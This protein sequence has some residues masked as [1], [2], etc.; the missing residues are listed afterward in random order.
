ML[1]AFV[2]ILI[3]DFALKAFWF[4]LATQ[5]QTRSKRLNMRWN[6]QKTNSEMNTTMIRLH[7]EL[8][9]SWFQAVSFPGGRW[10]SEGPPSSELTLRLLQCAPCFQSIAL[11]RL[12]AHSTTSV[13]GTHD[14]QSTALSTFQDPSG[15]LKLRVHQMTH[16]HT[17]THT[18]VHTHT[19]VWIQVHILCFFPYALQCCH[20]VA[21]ELTCP[22][23]SWP[24]WEVGT[25][26][27]WF[28]SSLAL[29]SKSKT[30]V[31]WNILLVIFSHGA[32]YTYC[33]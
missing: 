33:R 6:S 13:S 7:L 27:V 3:F 10:E 4:S 23:I 5:K 25:V 17:Y 2:G 9:S 21:A 22:S 30:S 15:C 11:R 19:D 20:I 26:P 28:S 32:S 31:I 16:M 14:E 12:R 8:Q 24:E 18:C 1:P 29:V